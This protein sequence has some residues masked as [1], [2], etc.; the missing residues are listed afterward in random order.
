MDALELPSNQEVLAFLRQCFDTEDDEVLFVK[1]F[2]THG[3]SEARDCY[4]EF[5]KGIS[6]YLP[7][8]IQREFI[9]R[10]KSH[11]SRDACIQ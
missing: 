9:E 8:C 7:S 2:E 10:S 3:I 5:K 1:V 6:A 4:R 11:D